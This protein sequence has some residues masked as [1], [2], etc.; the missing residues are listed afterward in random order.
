MI[1]DEYF[2]YNLNLNFLKISVYMKNWNKSPDSR[3][4][5]ATPILI[6]CNNDINRADKTHE[7]RTTSIIQNAIHRVFA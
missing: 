2:W 6:N 4:P 5:K 7:A 3:N 1:F